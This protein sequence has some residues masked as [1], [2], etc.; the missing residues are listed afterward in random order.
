LGSD[1][2]SLWLQQLHNDYGI[3]LVKIYDKDNLYT[4]AL[5]NAF[6]TH[7]E[8]DSMLITLHKEKRVPYVTGEASIKKTNRGGRGFV[9]A[10][11]SMLMKGPKYLTNDSFLGLSQ[12]RS[13]STRSGR[14]QLVSVQEPI[15]QK[16]DVK[17]VQSLAKH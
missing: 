15:S 16:K 5:L 4:V 17:G 11:T 2:A 6:R 3:L 9:V 7:H 10:S 1:F 13:Y 8:K 12:V 14:S